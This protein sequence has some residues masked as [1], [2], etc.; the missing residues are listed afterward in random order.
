MTGR[1]QTAR[2]QEAL[3]EA[4]RPRS[5]PGRCG[6]IFAGVSALEVHRDQNRC[7]PDHIT[8]SLLTIVDGVYVLRGSDLA[9]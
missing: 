9:R 3:A 4:A 7:L 8:E 2:E 5:C 1:E 6:R